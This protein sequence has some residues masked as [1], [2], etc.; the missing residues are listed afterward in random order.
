MRNSIKNTF[1]DRNI[2]GY[3][4]MYLYIY[5]HTYVHSTMLSATTTRDFPAA[6][7]SNEK[8]TLMSTNVND[9]L[10][11]HIFR[12]NKQIMYPLVTPK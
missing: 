6:A 11:T 10:S 12:I 7:L 9:L 4:S 5:V 3:I 1:L 2:N 8:I